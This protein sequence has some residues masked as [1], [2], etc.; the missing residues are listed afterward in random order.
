MVALIIPEEAHKRFAEYLA[1]TTKEPVI[2]EYGASA[3]YQQFIELLNK[4]AT[5]L[6][7]Q[8]DSRCNW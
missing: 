7:E 2:P 4:R 3:E 8:F 6:A 5:D 1:K